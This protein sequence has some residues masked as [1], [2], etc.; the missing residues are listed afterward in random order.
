MH[1]SNDECVQAARTCLWSQERGLHLTPSDK[2]P[3][4]PITNVNLTWATHD[5]RNISQKENISTTDIEAAAGVVDRVLQ[6]GALDKLIPKIVLVLLLHGLILLQH[7][8]YSYS[9]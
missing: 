1:S 8:S 6:V 3:P 7:A 2:F 9:A 4:C 5:L